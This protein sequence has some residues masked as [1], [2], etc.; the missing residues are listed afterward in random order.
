VAALVVL[1]AA[2]CAV[3]QDGRAGKQNAREQVSKATVSSGE[4]AE[5]VTYSY[6]FKK[7]EFFIRR[8][9][10]QHDTNGKGNVTFERQGDIEPIVEPLELSESARERIKALWSVLRFLDSSTDY[11]SERQYPHLGTMWLRMTNGSRSR[12]AELNWTND[13]NARA[14]IEEYRR[15]ANQIIFIFDIGVSRENQPLNSPKLLDLLDRYVTSKQLSDPQQLI[16]LLR[17]LSTDERLPLMSRNKAGRI[18][19]RIEN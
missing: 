12:V 15:V 11:Q 10:I 5:P 16:P 18:L 8:V 4:V 1:S 9:L 6:E 3:A 14:L 2:I 17:E 7:A 13:P 19:K